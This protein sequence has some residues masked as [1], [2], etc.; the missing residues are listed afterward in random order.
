MHLGLE[1]L[2]EHRK[3]FVSYYFIAAKGGGRGGDS[4][5]MSD[6]KLNTVVVFLQVS[7]SG[8]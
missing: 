3:S 2:I 4:I 6:L 5:L 1:R 7:Q 8:I